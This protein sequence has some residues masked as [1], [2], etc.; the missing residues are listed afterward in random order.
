WKGKEKHS[1]IVGEITMC[2]KQTHA[3]L[4]ANGGLHRP[5]ALE[6]AQDILLNHHYEKPILF[7]F[8]LTGSQTAQVY[9]DT[10]DEIVERFIGHG[11]PIAHVG[12]L[13]MGIDKGD[14]RARIFFIVET[15]KK[16]PGTT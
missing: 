13:E 3:I 9:R 14:L 1:M 7:Q 4:D 6:K 15:V 5:K 10:L 16:F 8:V 11:F 12:Y 2:K